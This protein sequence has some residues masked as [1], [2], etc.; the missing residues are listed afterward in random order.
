MNAASMLNRQ[1][2][3]GRVLLPITICLMNVGATPPSEGADQPE[4]LSLSQASDG[5]HILFRVVIRRPDGM[6]GMTIEQSPWTTR[7]TV[8]PRIASLTGTPQWKYPCYLQ[9]D[10][11][12]RGQSVPR[13][14][15]LT[16]IGR[17]PATTS[18][19]LK[20]VKV[21]S[22]STAP[23]RPCSHVSPQR[24]ASA[25]GSRRVLR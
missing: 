8:W 16:F 4:V 3:L 23:K 20:S 25:R 15:R 10:R 17:C 1:M 6:G 9:Y 24:D 11:P 5:Q 18:S 13:L 14:D 12:E 19:T 7:R 21:T 22:S 2:L